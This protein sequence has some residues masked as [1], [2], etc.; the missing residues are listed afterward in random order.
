MYET[1]LEPGEIIMAVTLPGA[2]E[3]GVREVSA[4]R[5]RAS[6]WSACSSRRRRAACASRSTGAGAVRVPRRSELEAALGKSFT[7]DGGERRR[8]LTRDGLNTR[9]ACV[10]GIPGAPHPGARGA[11]G[12]RGRL[13]R[14]IARHDAASVDDVDRARSSGTTTSPTAA[15]RPP[16]F[17]R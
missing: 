15:S 16:S 9:P 13:T 17:S 5:R 1:A 3:G 2:E 8:S 4:I 6:R 7:A 12:R 10:A 11:R 14:P